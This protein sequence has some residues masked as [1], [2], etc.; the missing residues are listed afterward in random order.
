M[1]IQLLK[2]YGIFI[3]GGALGAMVKWVICF[4]LTSLLG[5]YYMAA[6]LGG[7]LINVTVNYA[8]HRRVT[9]R[10]GGGVPRRF[11]YFLLLSS[12]TVVLSMVL[13]FGV[14]EYVLDALGS[15][16]VRGVELNYLVAIAGVTF[17]VSVVNYLVSRTYIFVE[18]ASSE[19]LLQE[20]PTAE[21]FM[22][23]QR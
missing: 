15:F 1:N 17:L 5:V 21:S 18:N 2:Q 20:K 7:E 13:V 12:I 8:W 19:N 6:L 14:K 22:T 10:V 4:F 23:G 3:L 16:T 9:F 11:F